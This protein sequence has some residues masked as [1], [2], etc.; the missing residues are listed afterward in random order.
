MMTAQESEE[1]II[2]SG[3]ETDEDPLGCSCI[4]ETHP[5]IS[6][7]QAEIKNKKIENKKISEA[8]ESFTKI[9]TNITEVLSL[10]KGFNFSDLQSSVNAL[11]AHALKQ[12]EELAVWAKSSTNMAWNLGS[13]LSGL[14]RAQN[15][16]QSSMSSL[17]EDTHS[18]KTMMTEMCEVFKGQ[19]SG[20]VTPTLALTHILANVKGRNDTNTTTKDPLSHTEEETNANRQ[21]KFKEPKHST[22]AN[23]EFIEGKGIATDEQVEDQRKLVKASSII[24]PD[25]DALIPYIINGEVY[26]LTAEQLQAHMD[27]EE[28]IKKAKEEA[29][30]FAISKPEVIKVVREEAKKLRIHPKEAITTKAGEKFK[31]AQDA[32]H[33]VLKRQHTEKVRKY[34][35]LR[36]H[37][38]DNYMW[39][40]NSRLKP[41]TITDI[42]IHPK[43]KPVVITVFRGTDGRNFDVYKPFAFGDFGISELDEL[44][45]IIPRKKNAVLAL[46]APASAP[47]QASSKSSRKKMK[48][49]ELEPEIKIPGLECNRALPK[50]VPFINNMV[51]EEPEYGIFFPDEFGDQ[52][53]QRWGNIDKVGMEALVSYLVAA[54]MVQSPKNA[55]MEGDGMGK[56]NDATLRR[57][58]RKRSVINMEAKHGIGKIFLS[59]KD[60]ELMA[61]LEEE[62]GVWPSDA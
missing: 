4:A 28:K 49:M 56:A 26:Y 11:R 27:K 21:E 19:S 53:F 55:R 39:T 36:K 13:R 23:I 57:V 10:V 42:K 14:E 2:E 44:R 41:E 16:I 38:Y 40:I 31:K 9:S 24:R 47:E 54:S 18:I 52:A 12:D 32:E 35:E 59:A 22:N 25:P 37:K 48:H 50:N 8:T 3:E 20:S 29:R 61:L 1:D 46:P 58:L 7:T 5:S 51:I 6:S 30:L 15:H 60:K 43:T 62:N 17:K 33:E 34:L 45:K